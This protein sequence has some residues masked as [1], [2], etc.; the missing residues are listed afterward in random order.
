MNDSAAA[1]WFY[2]REGEKMGPVSFPDLITEAREGRVNPRLDMV[3]SEGMDAWRPAGEIDGLFERR[4]VPSE[5]VPSADAQE[6]EMAAAGIILDKHSGWPGANRAVYLLTSLLFPVFWAAVMF[7]GFTHLKSLIGPE[8]AKW[9]S[10]I[11]PWVPVVVLL[12]VMLSRFRNLGMNRLWIFGQL[13]PLLNLW[14]GYRLFACPPGYP[15][16]KKMDGAGWFLAIVYWGL[17]VLSLAILVIIIAVVV[18]A[19]GDPELQKRL[20]EV[21]RQAR[22]AQPAGP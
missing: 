13:V 7:Y 16:H 19:L 5:A 9:A 14:V 15:W 4:D 8:E 12:A 3:W 1:H 2:T 20:E 11:L 6:E 21:V 22:E 18:G 10:L 17:I